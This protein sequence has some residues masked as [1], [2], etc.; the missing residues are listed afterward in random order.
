[1]LPE[2]EQ[3]ELTQSLPVQMTLFSPTM[4]CLI[5][6][7]PFSPNIFAG[8][9]LMSKLCMD[10]LKATKLPYLTKSIFLYQCGNEF[11]AV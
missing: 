4:Y 11:R 1:M 10:T 9:T 2:W 5:G 3:R 6:V 8:S 7:S